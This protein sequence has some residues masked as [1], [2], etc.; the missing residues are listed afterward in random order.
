MIRLDPQ[1]HGKIRVAREKTGHKGN[2]VEFMVMNAE[3]LAFADDRFD[4]VVGSGVLHHLNIERAYPE[5]SR[6]CAPHGHLVFCEP[7]GHNPFIKLYRKL[8]P[9][10]RTRD[11]HPLT[12]REIRLLDGF[13]HEVKTEFFSLLTL[14]AIPF[15]KMFFFEG[16]WRILAWADKAICRIPF[17]RR[18]SW[19]VLIHARDPRTTKT[20]KTE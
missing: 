12:V 19:M 14:S 17:I 9:N 4:L 20:E 7:L 11:E 18:Y 15:R 2:R 10:I 1:G 16:M 13:F 6:V 8:T 5:L 3:E